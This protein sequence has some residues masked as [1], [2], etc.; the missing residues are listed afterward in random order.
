MAY[1]SNCG[2][3]LRG[4]MKYCNKCGYQIDDEEYKIIKQSRPDAAKVSKKSTLEQLDE[5]NQKDEVLIK[6]EGVSKPG[7]EKPTE[8]E[9]RVPPGTKVK[10]KVPKSTS[11]VVCNRRTDDICFFCDYAVCNK[12]S[13]KMQ[14]IADKAKIG[15]VIE[16]CP[17]CARIKAGHQPTEEEAAE[18]GFFFKIKPYHEWKCLN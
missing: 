14:V 4:A 2:A 12:H 1:C 7:F 3:E 13:V 18:I 10:S 11:C 9:I 8:M 16:S 5:D 6:A 17:E 15:N